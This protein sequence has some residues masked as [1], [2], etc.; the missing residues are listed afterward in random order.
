MDGIV[1][2][3]VLLAGS[4]W[5]VGG[6][7]GVGDW[8]AAGVVCTGCNNYRLRVAMEALWGRKPPEGFLHFIGTGSTK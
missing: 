1:G 4:W 3:L 7:G 6:G 2:S 5:G 8:E